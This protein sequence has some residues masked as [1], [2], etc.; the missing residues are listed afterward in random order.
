MV[1]SDSRFE[2]ISELIEIFCFLG[3]KLTRGFF[4]GFRDIRAGGGAE[5]IKFEKLY[6]NICGHIFQPKEAAFLGEY[7]RQFA[8]RDASG[9]GVTRLT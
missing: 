8:L 6:Q 1:H 4:K 3:L 7:I 9:L 5:K 2:A